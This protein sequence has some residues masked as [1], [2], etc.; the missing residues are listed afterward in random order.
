MRRAQGDDRAIGCAPFEVAAVDLAPVDINRETAH[1]EVWSRATLREVFAARASTVPSSLAARCVDGEVARIKVW[2]AKAA[3]PL[4]LEAKSQGK[5]GQHSKRW[6]QV[7]L[8]AAS[9]CGWFV[10]GVMRWRA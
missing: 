5:E 8:F 4:L 3:A 6:R 1:A 9:E 2:D 7:H 10:R